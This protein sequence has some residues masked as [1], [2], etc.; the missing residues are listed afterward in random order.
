MTIYLTKYSPTPWYAKWDCKECG[1]VKVY[2]R[3]VWETVGLY[4]TA[5]F[6]TSSDLFL[7]EFVLSAGG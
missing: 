6:L 2:S 1:I 3:Y 7:D 4:V 5:W